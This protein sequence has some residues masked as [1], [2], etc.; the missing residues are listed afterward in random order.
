[1]CGTT[2]IQTVGSFSVS[3]SYVVPR[4]RSSRL[5]VS[6]LS[7]AAL[8]SLPTS[9]LAVPLPR[10]ACVSCRGVATCSDKKESGGQRD[11]YERKKMKREENNKK[12]RVGG[13]LSSFIQ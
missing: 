4:L 5:P 7:L 10:R 8:S 3:L 6:C 11:T 12:V 1:M 2:D 13:A 9:F